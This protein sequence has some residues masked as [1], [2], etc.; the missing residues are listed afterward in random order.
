MRR[1]YISL[2]LNKKDLYIYFLFH[3]KK[4]KAM[5]NYCMN[6]IC[7]HIYLIREDSHL[8][9]FA[10]LTKTNFSTNNSESKMAICAARPMKLFVLDCIL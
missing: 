6:N 8:K 5:Y 1:K 3:Q 9:Y 2:R 4:K 7:I 10:A